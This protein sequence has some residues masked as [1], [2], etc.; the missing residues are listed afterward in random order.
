MY[1]YCCL[2]SN[3]S[4]KYLLAYLAGSETLN[5]SVVAKI[6]YPG[7]LDALIMLRTLL[8]EP[9]RTNSYFANIIDRISKD[10][11]QISKLLAQSQKS[12]YTTGA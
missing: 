10:I 5:I 11:N 7:I 6:G 9:K 3:S 2:C 12:D 8:D 4:Q 1:Y